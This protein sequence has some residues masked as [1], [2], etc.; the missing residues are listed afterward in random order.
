MNASKELQN[1]KQSVNSHYEE[2][3]KFSDLLQKA[4]KLSDEE[5]QEASHLDHEWVAGNYTIEVR[6][7]FTLSGWMKLLYARPLEFP[8]PGWSNVPF[9]CDDRHWVYIPKG[10]ATVYYPKPHMQRAIL[11][12]IHS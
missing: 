1:K 6:D 11:T 5:L 9:E 2:M 8:S 7:F 12:E 4:M 3:K 10:T